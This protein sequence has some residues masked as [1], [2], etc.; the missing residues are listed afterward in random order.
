MIIVHDYLT[1]RGGAERLV[2]SMLRAL[3]DAELVTSIY[4]PS[5]TFPEF[6][7]HRIHTLWPSRVALLRRN[8]RLALPVLAQAFNSFSTTEDL[9]CSSSGW[10]HGARTT[11]RKTVYCYTPPRWV[12]APDSFRGGRKPT[13]AALRVVAPLL[14]RWDRRAAASA[15]VY[16]TSSQAMANRIRDVYRLEAEVLPPPMLLTSDVG[17]AVADLPTCYALVVS[18]LQ[19]YKN[20]DQAIEACSSLGIPLVVVGHGPELARLRARAIG[21]QVI[22]LQG[23]SEQQ[24]HRVYAKARVLIAPAYEDYG[25]TPLEAGAR[26]VPVV[27]LAEGGYLDTVIDDVTG[28]LYS[29]GSLK[30][31]LAAAL[32]R[33]WNPM[34]MRAHIATFSEDRFVERLRHV[35]LGVDA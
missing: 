13:A 10:A 7:E 9:L 32:G 20:V 29:R 4:E 35:V 26:G 25:F 27:A 18:R 19:P 12:Y 21:R 28:L 3:P 31:A 15:D 11:G 5:K 24:L 2:L 6:A 14:G 8:H 23:L 17:A 30:E 16:L 22:F 1:Q 33:T 34:V